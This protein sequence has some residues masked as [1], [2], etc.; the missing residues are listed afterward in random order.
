M[1]FRRIALA[2]LLLSLSAAAARA[3][4]WP[5]WRYGPGRGGA[6][7]EALPETLH[8]QW[9]RQLPETRP[10]WPETQPALRFDATHHPVVLGGRVLVASAAD[11]SVTAYDAA[12]GRERWK[13]FADGPVRFAPVGWRDRVFVA[14]DDGRL[15]WKV[16]GAPKARRIL[17]NGR[18]VSTWP[19]RGGPVL[20]GGV[21]YFTAGIWPSMGVFVHAVDA[22][23]GRVLWTNSETGSRYSVHPHGAPA[24]GSVAPQGYLAVAGDYLVVP[25]GRSMPAVFD[26]HT[27]AML[28]FEFGPKNG[29][30][31]HATAAKDWY[32]FEGG[33][34]R[35]ADGKKVT[36]V[37]EGV[38]GDDGLV[39][40]GDDGGL[41]VQSL[42]GNSAPAGN[43]LGRLKGEERFTPRLKRTFGLERG[44]PDR[45]LLRAGP[46]VYAARGGAIACFE[47]PDLQR[48]PAKKA[49]P[50]RAAWSAEVAG[51]VTEMFAADGRL[52]V[53]TD[54]AKLYCFGAEEAE[55]VTHA[56][57]PQPLPPAEDDW[58][59]RAERL[60]AAANVDGGYAVC[61]GV[62]S[63]RLAEELARRSRLHVIVLEPRAAA[64]DAFRRRA[65]AAGLYGERVAVVPAGLED[66]GLPPYL[67]ELIVSETPV[68]GI[69]PGALF[70]PLRPYGGAAWLPL[71]GEEH[72]RLARQVL[73]ARLEGAK[74]TRS[75]GWSVLAREGPLPGAGAWTHQYGDASNTGVSPDRL[76]KAPLGLLWFGGPDHRDVLPR[77]G[78][79]P[80][81]QVAGGRLFIE[82]PD[83]LRATDVYT[84]RLLW[85]RQLPGLGSYYNTT[86]H[87][88]GA[89]EVGSNYVSLPDAVYVIHGKSIL[90]L[91]AA[92]GATRKTF[93][94]KAGADPDAG[95]GFLAVW[96]DLLIA[97]SNP[98]QFEVT[99]DPARFIGRL[100]KGFE[101]LHPDGPRW[102]YLAGSDP[103]DRWA[104]PSFK[105][106]WETG[107]P[108]FGRAPKGEPGTPLPG[109]KVP[110]LYLR[111]S[112]DASA[113]DGA[114]ELA[115]AVDY[116]GAFIAYLNGEEIAR[117]GVGRGRGAKASRLAK[118]PARGHEFFL[119]EGFREFLRPGANVL[120]IEAHDAGG[121][122][123]IDPK[124]LVNRGAPVF[125]APDEVT[126]EVKGRLL[127]QWLK[128]A[129]YAPASKR[130]V[131][132]DRHSGE[133]L[134]SREATFEFRHNAIAAGAGKVFCIDGMSP[135]KLQVLARR[136]LPAGGE[137]RL[138]ALDARSGAVVWE[139]GEDVFGTF[140]NYHAGRDVLLQAGSAN[141][142]RAWDEVDRGMAA[143]R[144][145]DGKVLWKDPKLRY[146][147]PC[148]LWK[149]TVITNGAAGFQLDLLTGE[150][151]GWK[152]QRMYGC[153]T[154]IGSEHL[155]TFRSGAAGFCDV[156][157]DGGTGNL[158]GF[159]SGCTSNLIIA[160]G[161]LSAPD[162]T[163]TCTCAYQNQCSLAFVHDPD[164]ELW[165]FGA[166]G[167]DD[168]GAPK[169][170]G[171][172]FGAPGDRRDE[173]GTLWL[174]YPSVGGPSPEVDVR[175]AGEVEWFRR[176][177]ALVSGDGPR[178]VAA[179]GGKGVRSVTVKVGEKGGPARRW[180][181]RLHFAEPDALRPGERV[182]SV[183]LQGEEVL[184]DFDV[185]REAGGPNRTL[186]REFKGVRAGET[187]ELRLTP[188]AGAKAA[189]LLCGLEVVEERGR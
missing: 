23:T 58:G 189:P 140:L 116:A 103:P 82:G 99:P 42:D 177:S 101:P 5:M 167:A 188:A 91:D 165:T 34:L 149:D 148:L 85:Q 74:L 122:L 130:L 127:K 38:L 129:D 171:L 142:D 26:R 9:V 16:R 72:R 55:P 143:H 163:R 29:G 21:V 64:A 69:D 90:E 13:F 179:S 172:N 96:D 4:D 132:F 63:G 162:Y 137:T 105:A 60:L 35:L 146:S 89:G 11:D 104:E 2:A 37:P 131:V 53:V 126:P 92:T 33:Q 54:A 15:R 94:L 83:S 151:T 164:A 10:A 144:G 184:K 125:S 49:P 44:A 88:P 120:A 51:E 128:P 14:A 7:P 174:D 169:R 102:Q 93:R 31:W 73:A 12:T 133:P 1:T 186:V 113:L 20:A 108:G 183:A 17:G 157:S 22:E 109:G 3:G 107:T 8:L 57:G 18:L 138:L 118:H 45:V 154:I 173:S 50:L 111:T 28:H 155:L 115:L 65:A 79:G 80:A 41:V 106:G 77:H 76:V 121:G 170:I 153:N 6:T 124:L 152:Y 100:P 147:G 187:L 40:G 27:G 135:R 160:D 59:A 180:T 36:D 75:E 150:P 48:P 47:L 86:R 98:V 43:L 39:I 25:G 175:V 110:R 97:T 32:L 52:F 66:A 62:G 78:H 87:F 182:F 139:T 46:R 181:V 114:R 70:R 141:R 56:P 185:V 161:V 123:W 71:G 61:L 84:G 136:G 166:A 156:A 68:A 67:A 24:F 81:P 159:R 30:G 117:A 168:P 112:F 19:A 176:H 145:A 95:W 119:V 158:G 178:W 134:W